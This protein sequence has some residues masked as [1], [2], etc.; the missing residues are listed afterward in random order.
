MTPL[1]KSE[2]GAPSPEWTHLHS[3]SRARPGARELLSAPPAP[4]RPPAPLRWVALVGSLSREHSDPLLL[5]SGSVSKMPGCFSVLLPTPLHL[6]T[7]ARPMNRLCVSKVTMPQETQAH[8]PEERAEEVR[9]LPGPA[10]GWPLRR[11]GHGGSSPRLGWS[12][13]QMTVRG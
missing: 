3:G 2:K 4:V 13:G 10:R 8:N 11:P 6:T 5:T 1:F 7:A 12:P 9:F